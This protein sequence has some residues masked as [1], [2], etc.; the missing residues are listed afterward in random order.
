MNPLFGFVTCFV[1]ELSCVDFHTHK[2]PQKEFRFMAVPYTSALAQMNVLK[3]LQLCYV[4]E[5]RKG[6]S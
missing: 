2:R 3:K 6:D 5:K 1:I 4:I